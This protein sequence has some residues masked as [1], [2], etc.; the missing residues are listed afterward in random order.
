[1]SDYKHTINLPATRFPMKADLA[2]REPDW[3]TAWQ[4]NGLYAKLRER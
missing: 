1:M 3:V 2:R 4:A